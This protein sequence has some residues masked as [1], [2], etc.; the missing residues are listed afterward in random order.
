MMLMPLSAGVVLVRD[1][2]DLDAA[3]AQRAPYLFHGAEGA[4]SP[5]QGKRS[6]Q[7]SRRFDALKVWVALQ[8]YGAEGL[9]ALY[10][11]LCD[12]AA[13]APRGDRRPARLRGAPRARVEH[14]LLPLPRRRPLDRGERLDALNLRLRE[15][16]NRSG[17]GWITTTMLDG[18][19]VLRV[20]VMNPRTTR[21]DVERTLDRLA[22]MAGRPPD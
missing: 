22:A 2:R 20:T 18:K 21:D 3:F 15:A 12:T 1:E 6:F 10:D 16:F 4:R 7:C 9:G 14:P 8:R 11:R 17:E 5:D 19:R 13:G